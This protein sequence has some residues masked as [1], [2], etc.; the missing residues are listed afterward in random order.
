MADNKE[1]TNFEKVSD[2]LEPFGKVAKTAGAIFGCISSAIGLWF[3]INGL[4]KRAKEA[5]EG[6][7]IDPEEIQPAAAEPEPVVPEEVDDEDFGNLFGGSKEEV[8]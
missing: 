1:T 4:I 6:E 5:K 8:E 2:R 3:K 7:V